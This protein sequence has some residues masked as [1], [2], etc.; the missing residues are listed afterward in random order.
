ML[1]AQTRLS[2]LVNGCPAHISALDKVIKV[3]AE[4]ADMR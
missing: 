2:R 3:L 1:Q 4:T